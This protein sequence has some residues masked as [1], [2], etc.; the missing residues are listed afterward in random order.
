MAIEAP[1][2][3]IPPAGSVPGEDAS[4]RWL[5]LTLEGRRYAL[6]LAAVSDLAECGLLRPVPRAPDWVLG[7]AERRGRIVTV[8]DLA[9]LL[10]RPAPGAA[11]TLVR[12][13]PPR[14][15]LALAV[16]TPPQHVSL[17]CGPSGAHAGGALRDHEGPLELLEP[18]ALLAAAESGT[19]RGPRP[20]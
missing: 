7:L 6:P 2:P 4:H 16:P 15:D 19:I 18:G 12:L 20:R 3:P 5:V 8:L 11:R 9:R 10:G 1:P 14:D 13:A 17:A